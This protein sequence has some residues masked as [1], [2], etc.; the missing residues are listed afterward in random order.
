M[1][2]VTAAARPPHRSAL[3]RLRHTKRSPWL[4]VNPSPHFGISLRSRRRRGRRTPMASVAFFACSTT[5]QLA[6]EYSKE[7]IKPRR[8]TSARSRPRAVRWL[9]G[10]AAYGG[11]TRCVALLACCGTRPAEA[12]YVSRTNQRLRGRTFSMKLRVPARSARTPR[13]RS[14]SGARGTLAGTRVL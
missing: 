2:R 7:G 3:A 1:P 4:I 5:M 12:R 6:A 8:T 9:G 10:L 14:C 11:A 13:Q